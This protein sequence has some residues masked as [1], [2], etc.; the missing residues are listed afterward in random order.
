MEGDR[1]FL[2]SEKK[3]GLVYIATHSPFVP[4]GAIG[5]GDFFLGCLSIWLV[6][7]LLGATVH[8]LPDN[9]I[10]PAAIAVTIFLVYLGAT[11]YTKRFIDISPGVNAKLVQVILFSLFIIGNV[12]IF[13]QPAMLIEVKKSIASGTLSSGES[14]M[15]SIVSVLYVA[16]F[17][18]FFFLNAYLFLKKG[19]QKYSNTSSGLRGTGEDDNSSNS[20]H[21]PI[22]NPKKVT[23]GKNKKMLVVL[24]GIVG[25]LITG[26]QY[27]NKTQNDERACLQR[28]E[29]H[30]SSSNP[31][32][33]ITDI[34]GGGWR[35]FKTQDEA[36]NYCMKVLK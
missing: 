24:I 36:M 14:T 35:P 10:T 31:S 12:V 30:G 29:F 5:R 9:I 25:I 18:V 2:Q 15:M 7:F 3:E 34:Q 13:V 22:K 8:F 28:V 23:G 6:S 16:S 21:P 26:W 19:T 32:Y 1:V 33:R 17:S 20:N 4:K 27:Y 11:W